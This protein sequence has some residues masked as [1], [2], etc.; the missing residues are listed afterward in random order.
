MI[1]NRKAEREQELGPSN[2]SYLQVRKRYQNEISLKKLVETQKEKKKRSKFARGGKLDL[3]T[4]VFTVNSYSQVC[5]QSQLLRDRGR[6][7]TMS[8]KLG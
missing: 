5:L 3:R 4:F 8:S 6:R 1:S 7:I 2:Q